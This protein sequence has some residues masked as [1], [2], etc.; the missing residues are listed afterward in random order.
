LQYEHDQLNPATHEALH[1]FFGLASASHFRHL[2]T[3]TRQEQLVTAAGEDAY[4]PH[5][6]RLAIPMAYIHGA[7]NESWLPES[8]ELT[9]QWLR[10]HNDRRLYS[11]HL[12]ANYGHLDCLIG[13]MAAKDV[14][15]LI[16]SHLEQTA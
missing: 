1:E 5:V 11:R 4:L 16:L 15:P 9:F 3:L 2:S 14:Y 8:T 7:E 12:V 10:Q 6:K 13:Q